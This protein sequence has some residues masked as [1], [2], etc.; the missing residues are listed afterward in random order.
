MAEQKESSV[1]FS[2]KELMNLEEDR[3]RQ[4][5][6]QKRRTDE[7]AARVHA[8]AERRVR[9]E[10][11]S[12]LRA[13][14]EKRRTE[15]QR[16][17][18]EATRLEAIRHGEVEKARIDAENRARMQQLQHQQEHER[19]LAVVTQDK[20]KKT[21]VII[22]SSIGVLLVAGIVGGLVLYTNAQ[23]KERD[24]QAQLQDLQSKQEEN[25]RKM[26]ELNSQLSHATTPE[27]RAQL[28][29]QIE[30]A[31]KKQADLV[32]QQNSVKPGTG[33]GGGGHVTP[34]QPKNL[35]KCKCS[36]QGDPLCNE[37]PGQT[38]QM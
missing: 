36:G 3:I 15:E 35:P 8:E 25:N 5:E 23:K 10:E 21:L 14:E 27:E 13:V 1:L 7:E 16:T 17:R 31:K 24:L 29:Q 18:E 20:S 26:N 32:A 38:C 37:L 2:L 28:E 34:A 22:S 9:E 6:D 4:E 33:G 11:E 12:R 30:D 19:Q